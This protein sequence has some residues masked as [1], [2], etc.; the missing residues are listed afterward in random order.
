MTK[1]K[2]R[3]LIALH[4]AL[5]LAGL[6]AAFLP[7]NYSTA[8]SEAYANEPISRF[9]DNDWF[10]LTLAL[11]LL[12]AWLAGLVGLWSFKRWG[13]S[14]SLYSTVAALIAVPL[15]GPTLSSGIESSLFEAATLC[16]GAVLALAYYSVVSE[17]FLPASH[18]SQ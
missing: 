4:L 8:L 11:I 10:W 15:F 5:S 14:L 17:Q 12:T 3:A 13:R 1:K 18:P 2:F 9:I 16:W 6:C 7:D